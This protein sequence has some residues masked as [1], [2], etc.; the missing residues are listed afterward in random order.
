[1]HSRPARRAV[2]WYCLVFFLGGIPALTYQVAWQR[3]LKLYFG[4]DI[5]STAVIV[6][7]FML[8]LGIGALIGGRIADA[9]SRPGVLYAWVELT[10]GLFGAAS[11]FVF[12]WIGAVLG[13]AALWVV[14]VVSF[15]MLLVPTTLMG[16]TLPLISRAVIAVDAHLG[17]HFA[18]LYSVNTLGAAAG[19][20]VTAYLL[21]GLLGLRGATYIAAALNI[22]LALLILPVA[23]RAPLGAAMEGTR[24]PV[25]GESSVQHTRADLGT[26]AVLALSFLSGFMALGLELVWY[27]T[28]DCLLHATIYVFGTILFVYLLGIAWGS[29]LSR[30][31]IDRRG[32]PVRFAVAQIGISLYT[33]FLFIMLTRAAN[34]PGLRH[35]LGASFF[36]SFHPAPELAAGVYDIY[37]LYSIAG[38]VFWTVLLVL[39]PTILMGIGFPNLVRAG[40]CGV[41]TLGGSVSGILFAN[42]IG[43]TLGS[44]LT[45]FAAL[46]F[47]GTER[48]LR[49][50]ALVGLV[51]P[52]VVLLGRGDR[53]PDGYRLL[54]LRPRHLGVAAALL[55]AL[56]ALLFPSQGTVIRAI[57]YA[58]NDRVEAI[59]REDRSG[60][61]VLRRQDA[62]LTFPQ[63]QQVVGA[64]R[65]YI[66]GSSHGQFPDGI[67]QVRLD[68]DLA[69]AL[70]AHPRPR[71]VLSIGLG[72]GVM[73][74]TVARDAR[75]QELV[76]VELC[77]SLLDVLQQTVQGRAIFETGKVRYI[78]DD[79][80]RWLLANPAEHFDMI[81]MFPLHAAHAYYGNLYSLEFLKILRGRLSS[82]GLFFTRTIDPYSSARTI[83]TVFP[84]V[85]RIGASSYVGALQEFV[86]DARI[87]PVSAQFLPG[88]IQADSQEI[89]DHSGGAALNGDL[90]PNSEF[91]LTYPFARYVCPRI[92]DHYAPYR[93]QNA[94]RAYRLSNPPRLH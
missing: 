71:R 15:A 25:E 64:W 42:I 26:W 88:L 83:A 4:V 61:V 6:A 46:H 62:V 24:T 23:R 81:I 55:G 49:A 79:G 72:D 60:I 77:S 31:T 44:L 87:L 69:L 74:A 29:H 89:L 54:G 63:E 14:G 39:P 48:T 66:D 80:R 13:G 17:R 53:G 18:L 85:L 75:V 73:C 16:M 10:L 43:A 2:T 3:V 30:R 84:R 51:G 5:E 35:L 7:T 36:T 40:T 32:A 8:G 20:L 94:T 86:F 59:A 9:S 90:S 28:L 34:L 12:G 21:C 67:D 38:L 19:A 57:H 27:R 41:R 78:I 76:I 50:L 70:A 92:A 82:D 93:L 33:L 65:L 91:Y 52:L 37:S 45:G 47:F 56:G 58:S 68:D 1:M 22:A 11:L